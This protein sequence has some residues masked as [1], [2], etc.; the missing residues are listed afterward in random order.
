MWIEKTKHWAA[1][2]T[3]E[4]TL[5]QEQIEQNRYYCAKIVVMVKYMTANEVAFR[6]DNPKVGS[7]QFGMF[8]K[9]MDFSCIQSSNKF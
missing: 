4:D 9:M 6:D 2:K 7:I 5:C 1:K 3:V 8:L